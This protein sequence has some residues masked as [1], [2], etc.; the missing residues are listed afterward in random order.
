MGLRIAFGLL[1]LAGPAFPFQ[2]VVDEPPVEFEDPVGDWVTPH[3]QEHSPFYR[4]RFADRYADRISSGA[5]YSV[6]EELVDTFDALDWGANESARQKIVSQLREFL[7]ALNIALNA[8][9]IAAPLDTETEQDIFLKR[10]NELRFGLDSLKMEE[11]KDRSGEDVQGYFGG[12]PNEILLYEWIENGAKVRLLLKRTQVREW[13]LLQNALS[14]LVHDQIRLVRRANVKALQ[15]A[16]T[17]WE[18]YLD[19]GYSQMPWESLVN[20]WL[21]DAPELGPPDHQWTIL[22]PSLGVELSVDP[23]D[24][25]R[26]KEAMHVEVLGH[27]WYRGDELEDYW[28]VSATVSLRSDLDPGLGFLVHVKRNWNVGVTWHDVDEDPFLFLSVDLFSFA[29][30]K[31]PKYVAKYRQQRAMLGLD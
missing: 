12:T 19:K 24:D 9:G 30:K 10:F 11:L 21:I 5:I 25:A 6:A 7:V 16:V 17:R 22:H 28:G 13:R 23:L 2:T 15:R 14:N 4:G 8:P 20:G 27:V 29:K 3:E 1:L 18:N 31:A 26:V